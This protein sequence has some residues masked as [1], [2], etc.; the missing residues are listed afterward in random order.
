LNAELAAKKTPD[1]E[2][3]ELGDKTDDPMNLEGNRSRKSDT[4]TNK[5]AKARQAT[6][7]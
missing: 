2:V 7:P 6:T 1:G 4:A 5:S 3:I